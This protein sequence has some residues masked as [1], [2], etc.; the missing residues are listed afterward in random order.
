VAAS[1][2]PKTPPPLE[3]WQ[4][5]VLGALQGV[6]ELFP[7]SSIG[8][9][10]IL[11]ALL[12]W[13]NVVA[14]Q[15]ANES[16]WLAFIV[17]LHVGTAIALLVYYWRDWVKI[18]GGVVRSVPAR[19]MVTPDARL[20]WLLIVATIPAG[21]T[22]VLF[23]H[24]L[25]VLFTKP[26]AASIFLMVN[27]LI[28]GFGEWYR[29]HRARPDQVEPVNT[30]A[31]APVGGASA[32]S[33]PNAD[34]APGTGEQAPAEKGPRGRKNPDL[35]TLEF[36]EA[37]VIG[38]AQISALFAGISRSGVAIVAGLV[39]GL[40]YSDAARFSFLLATPVIF[41]AG[42]Y[43]LPDLLGGNGN[44]V[45][46]QSLV[47]AA[48]ACLAAYLSVSFLSRYFRSRTLLPFAIYCCAAGLA[49]TIHFA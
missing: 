1:H 21:I 19:R 43:K 13:N 47:G 24:E 27:G 30:L 34:D 31:V 2:A 8:H 20:G 49:F 37:G 35:D 22:G 3:Y 46:G 18:V 29:R 11:P 45:R 39:R 32:A 17:G 23:E 10:V 16:F 25:R 41:L 42:I 44:G 12:G 38:V 4:A 9:T 6:T 7:V 5:I 15:S 26:L 28:L 40:N 36:K 14:A 48:A 33:M